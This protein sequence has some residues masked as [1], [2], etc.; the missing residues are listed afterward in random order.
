MSVQDRVR[1]LK[2]K[3]GQV[4]TELHQEETRPKPDDARLAYLK[5]EKLALKDEMQRLG[6]R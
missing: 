3:H 5:R 4:E 1:S 6:A 2:E